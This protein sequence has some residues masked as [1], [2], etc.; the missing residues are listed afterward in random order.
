MS[1]KAPAKRAADLRRV[2]E[3]HNRLYYV[4]DNPEIG[5]DASD[6]LLDVLREIEQLNP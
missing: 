3:R 5:D 6:R 1:A 4:E 2:L